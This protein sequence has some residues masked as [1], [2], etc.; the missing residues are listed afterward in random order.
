MNKKKYAVS[1]PTAVNVSAYNHIRELKFKKQKQYF[2]TF[3]ST[4]VK[5]ANLCSRI[6]VLKKLNKSLWKSSF[7]PSTKNEK[8][9]LFILSHERIF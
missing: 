5:W 7:V 8:I 6:P 4:H 9:E 3:N 1:A 2:S